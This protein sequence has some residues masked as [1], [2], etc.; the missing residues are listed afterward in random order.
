MVA[1]GEEAFKVASIE[2][3]SAPDFTLASSARA[4]ASSALG[5]TPV[6]LDHSSVLPG[7]ASALSDPVLVLSGHVSLS[8]QASSRR[9]LGGGRHQRRGGGDRHPHPGGAGGLVPGEEQDCL[10][11]L[12]LRVRM[13]GP[14]T[15]YGASSRQPSVPFQRLHTGPMRRRPTHVQAP[16]GSPLGRL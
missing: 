16:T 2:V 4:S 5:S 6:S 9:H 7:R 11:S 14:F 12:R 13:L 3:L 15:P 10:S 1:S 8:G